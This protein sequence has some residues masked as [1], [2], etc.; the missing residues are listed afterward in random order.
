M[1]LQK[2]W[3]WF[4]TKDDITLDEVKQTNVTGVVTAFHELPTGE[5]WPLEKFRERKALIKKA[6]LQ[7]TVVE[8]IPVHEDI[9]RRTG[10]YKIW[11]DH[12]KQSIENM[13]RCGIP[14]LCYNFMPILDWTRTDLDF[15][16]T[17][18]YTAL[19]FDETDMAVFDLFILKRPDAENEYTDQKIR[20]AETLF[21]IMYERRKK[22]LTDTILAGLPGSEEGYTL[23]EFQSILDTYKDIRAED[24]RNNLD[25]FLHEIVPVAEKAGVRLA[26]HPDDPPFPLFGLPRV[27]STEDDAR[28]LTEVVDTPFN[29]LTFCTGSY[30]V[31]AD[32]DLPGMVERLGHR[33]NFLHLR[34]VQRENGR[35]FHEAQHIRGSVNMERVIYNIIM[36][37][38]HRKQEKRSDIEIPFRPDHGHNILSGRL[39]NTKPGYS[40]I[41][42][43]RGLAVLRGVEMGIRAALAFEKEKETMPYSDPDE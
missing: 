15:E 10:N 39:K 2:T 27:V 31:R 32:N 20:E 34:N 33:I 23:N 29:G 3:R 36:E 38:E 14:V 26:I 21:N 41:G 19:R 37:Q 25:D 24:L 40:Y 42:R 12:N 17:S 9:K 1:K 18:G 6:G 43:L 28:K 5:V 13:G 8:S 4:G 30:G 16:T 22:K 35:T 11:I 7:W